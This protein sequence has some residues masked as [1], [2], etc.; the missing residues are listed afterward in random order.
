MIILATFMHQK[1][2]K[3]DAEIARYIRDN[4]GI[5]LTDSWELNMEASELK[6]EEEDDND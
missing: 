3:S 4:P 2:F 6:A 1:A 5:L